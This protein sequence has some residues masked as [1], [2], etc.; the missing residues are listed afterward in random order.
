MYVEMI[1]V[2]WLNFLCKFVS[3][4]YLLKL[5]LSHYRV[6]MTYKWQVNHNERFLQNKS[7]IWNILVFKAPRVSVCSVLIFFE[8]IYGRLDLN[9]DKAR[10][11]IWSCVGVVT[12]HNPTIHCLHS[13]LWREEMQVLYFVP[14]VWWSDGGPGTVFKLVS[15]SARNYVSRVSGNLW[16]IAFSWK[17]RA[18]HWSCKII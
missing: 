3:H 15:M 18:S 9:R 14:L 4:D 16:E 5:S 11:Q 13:L 10:C 7:E 8:Y 2:I 1:I 12:T 6:N 17:I